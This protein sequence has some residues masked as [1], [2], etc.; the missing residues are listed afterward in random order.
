MFEITFF[1][2]L[3]RNIF[4]QKTSRKQVFIRRLSINMIHNKYH[5]V[6][7]ENYNIYS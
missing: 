5:T 6:G 1:F 7:T 3:F 4:F 2:L